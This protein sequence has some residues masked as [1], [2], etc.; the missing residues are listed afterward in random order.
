MGRCTRTRNLQ[1][2]HIRRDLGNDISNAQVLCE[3]C[4]AAAC[5]YGAAGGRTPQFDQGIQDRALRNAE[6]Q[7]QC[8]RTSGCH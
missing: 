3:Q 7:C 2:H 8:I 4:R 1:V 5:S 6:N